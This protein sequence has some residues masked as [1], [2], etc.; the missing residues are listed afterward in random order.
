MAE[1]KN[2][3][4]NSN[5]T[6]SLIIFMILI[7]SVFLIISPS[8]SAALSNQEDVAYCIDC[9]PIADFSYAPLDPTI[10][11]NIQFTDISIVYNLAKSY[12]EYV[13]SNPTLPLVAWYW[14]FDDGTTSDLTNPTHQYNSAGTYSVSLTITDKYGASDTVE[15]DITVI[16]TNIAPVADFS[17][18]PSNPTTDD[19]IQ[20]TDDST[21]EDG[22]IAGWYWNF[23]DGITSTQQNPSHQFES[24]NTYNVQLKVTDNA[25]DIATHTI[26]IT[27]SKPPNQPPTVDDILGQTINE[28]EDFCVIDLTSSVSDPDNEPYEITWTY[29]GNEFIDI[30]ILATGAGTVSYYAQIYY[31]DDWTG[32]ETVTFTGAD[33]DGLSDSDSATFTVLAVNDLPVAVDDYVTIDMDDFNGKIDVLGNDYDPDGAIIEI[34]EVSNGSYAATSHDGSFVYYHMP[35]PISPGASLDGISDEFSYKI[36]DDDGDFDTGVVFVEII[37]NDYPPVVSDIPD[38]TINES[39][40]F[41][42]ISLNDF[43]TDSDDNFCSLDWSVDGNSNLDVS[44]IYSECMGCPSPSCYC[45]ASITYQDGWTGSET[46]TF[47]VTDPDGLSDSDSATF[48]VNAKPIPPT[49]NQPPVISD[50]SVDP[51]YEDEFFADIYLNAYVEDPDGSDS[52]ITWTVSESDVLDIDIL[53][54]AAVGGDPPVNDLYYYANITYQPGW[55]GSE[56]VTFIVTDPDGL[57]DSDNVTFTVLEMPYDPMGDEDGDGVINEIED[58]NGD[59]DPTNDDTDGDG[60][61][62]YEDNDDDGDGIL[63]IDEDLNGDG[64]PTNDDSDEDGIPEYLDT[65][66]DTPVIPAPA[67]EPPVANASGP[68][69]GNVS[70]NIIFNASESYDPD[71]QI[72][73]YTWDFGDGNVSYGK[74]VEHNYS[75]IGNYKI[76]LTVKDNEGLTSTN[77]TSAEITSSEEQE[78]EDD[79]DKEANYIPRSGGGGSHS[80]PPMISSPVDEEPEE[81]TPEEEST[82]EPEQNKAPVAIVHINNDGETSKLDASPSTDENDDMLQFRW[83]YENDGV[84]DTEYSNDPVVYLDY[85]DSLT[86]DVRVEVFDGELSDEE[87]VTVIFE[88]CETTVEEIEESETADQDEASSYFVLLFEWWWVLVAALFLM[89]VGLLIYKKREVIILKMKSIK[90][91]KTETQE[92]QEF[93]SFT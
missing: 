67:N 4:W 29:T 9:P 86:L 90:L 80:S 25:G 70:E 14:D 75:S 65:V 2:I 48:T 84:W 28:G 19:N 78:Q 42:I 16:S 34:V 7:F 13:W 74:I 91:K 10:D 77:T 61:P 31:N 51:I 59:G 57:S 24:I 44:I 47:I 37:D 82:E 88:D 38:Q 92:S 87:I 85:I 39:E 45:S 63:T 5:R 41:A 21:D 83:D 35:L 46:V 43:V 79:E 52:D 72:V 32:S 93:F 36:I 33:P 60:I 17:Y 55:T 89:V 40:N 54:V 76:N 8:I 66:D 64:D 71:G 1:S 69:L 49:P 30:Q 15:K 6:L 27:V 26:P 18:S 53:V 68:Y 22:S 56:T 12:K 62:D 23:G 73:N 81:E 50:I 58:L 11:D 20:F 3:S